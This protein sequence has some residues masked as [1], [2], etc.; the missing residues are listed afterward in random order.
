M[1]H[2]DVVVLGADIEGLCAAA[3]LA[4]A[5]RNVIVVDALDRPG[6]IV[7]REE[8]HPGYHT[9]G[10]LHDSGGV[11]RRLIEPLAL[12][13]FGLN[14]RSRESSALLIGDGATLRWHQSAEK[15]AAELSHL[16]PQEAQTLERWHAFHGR[17]APSLVETTQ[18]NCIASKPWFATS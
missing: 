13:R 12:E 15:T 5:G 1:K 9:L 2:Y 17:I 4:Q 18:L 6:G 16:E 11:R 7:A 14:W 8:F 10:L 3:H